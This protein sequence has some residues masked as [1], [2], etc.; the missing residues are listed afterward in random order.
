MNYAPLLSVRHWIKVGK[1]TRK[2]LAVTRTNAASNPLYFRFLNIHSNSDG[3]S[4]FSGWLEKSFFWQKSINFDSV[5]KCSCWLTHGTNIRYKI[6][7]L[8]LINKINRYWSKWFIKCQIQQ[9]SLAGKPGAYAF[10]IRV[11]WCR[12]ALMGVLHGID[13]WP[14]PISKPVLDT[15]DLS[16]LAGTPRGNSQAARRGQTAG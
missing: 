11:K 13:G 14:L 6:Q 8:T 1:C 3:L 2:F 10:I 15:L 7:R 9:L 16:T 4:G 5:I 12:L